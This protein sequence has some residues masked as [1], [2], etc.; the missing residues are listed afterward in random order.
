MAR[1]IAIAL[2]IEDRPVLSSLQFALAVDGFDARDGS[3]QGG[4]AS[5]A[6][7]VIDQGY[8][9]DGLAWLGTLRAGGSFVPAI[10]LATNP[11]PRL[12][13]RA[14]ETGTALIEKPLRFHELRAAID[15]ALCDQKAA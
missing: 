7:L 1:K 12:R 15:A 11:T 3:S 8:R 2:L 5:A 13:A 14:R 10:L 4:L 9:G 6:A